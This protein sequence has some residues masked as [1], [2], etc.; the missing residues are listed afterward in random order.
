MK[1]SE[2]MQILINCYIKNMESDGTDLD[3]VLKAD[4]IR[5]KFEKK[6]KEKIEKEEVP[7]N[8]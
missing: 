5:K 6:E 2:V 3:L 7:I 1:K 8:E 4:N